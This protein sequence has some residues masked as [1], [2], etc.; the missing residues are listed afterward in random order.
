LAITVWLRRTGRAY[1]YTALP[2]AFVMTM[3][4]WSLAVLARQP[5]AGWLGG[6]MPE[7]AVFMNGAVALVLI[8]LALV[9]LRE[10]WRAASKDGWHGEV[11]EA[12]STS[13]KS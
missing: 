3:T 1:W 6:A 10:G 2:M 4:L 11:G 12:W 13:R 5:L 7:M 8:A 9:L